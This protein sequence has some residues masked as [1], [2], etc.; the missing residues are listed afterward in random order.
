MT[1]LI[2]IFNSFFEY[3]FI[4]AGTNS[5]SGFDDDDSNNEDKAHYW[6]YM[7][8]HFSQLDSVKYINFY[9]EGATTS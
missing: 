8:S 3:G 4:T 6:E 7:T 2:I 1:N 9:Y 5:S